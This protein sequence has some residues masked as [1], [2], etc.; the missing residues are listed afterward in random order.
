MKPAMLVPPVIS[1][2]AIPSIARAFECPVHIKAAQ[3]AIITTAG[4]MKG[5]S[6]EMKLTGM[7][8]VHSLLDDAKMFITMAR[9]HH[10]KPQG[11][12][13]H[14]RSIAKA[15]AAK[16]FADA[17]LIPMKKTIMSK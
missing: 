6:K 12:F 14:A 16:G 7:P 1:L 2:L 15:D 5:M 13:D 8:L 11:A 10:S 4:A 9:H 3:D 17:A